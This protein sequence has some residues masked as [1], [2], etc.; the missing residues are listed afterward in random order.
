MAKKFKRMGFDWIKM[1]MQMNGVNF[2]PEDFVYF[3]PFIT[4]SRVKCE[5]N[6]C[7]SKITSKN[8]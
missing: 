7:I 6:F 5:Q 4:D 3:G 2:F 8:H 1:Q